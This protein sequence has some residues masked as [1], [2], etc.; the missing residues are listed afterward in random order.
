MQGTQTNRRIGWPTK[1]ITALTMIGCALMIFVAVSLLVSDAKADETKPSFAV[2][3]IQING[4]GASEEI[5]HESLIRV[6]PMI[7]YCY[8]VALEIEPDFCG[9]VLF[10]VDINKAS[11]SDARLVRSSVDDNVFE[12]CVRSRLDRVKFSET[13][14]RWWSGSA[15]VGMSFGRYYTE[16][17]YDNEPGHHRT[18]PP[19]SKAPE[20]LDPNIPPDDEEED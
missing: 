14:Q 2:D 19:V 3:V 9:S 11:L 10:E 4:N 8:E 17:I 1:I 6:A 16:P 12:H 20:P 15:T 5:L 7:N 13:D 18:A